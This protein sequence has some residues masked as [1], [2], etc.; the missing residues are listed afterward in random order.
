MGELAEF[1]SIVEWMYLIVDDLRILLVY[2]YPLSSPRP[3]MPISVHHIY[4]HHRT[5]KSLL[6]SLSGLSHINPSV[7]LYAYYEAAIFV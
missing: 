3:P 2:W 1:S 4:R 7:A 5:N 6:L